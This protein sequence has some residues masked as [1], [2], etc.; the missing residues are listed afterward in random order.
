[1]V[2]DEQQE[3]TPEGLEAIHNLMSVI[4]NQLALVVSRQVDNGIVLNRLEARME[5]LQGLLVSLYRRSAKDED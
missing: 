3:P 5:G 2:S 1:M 4:H